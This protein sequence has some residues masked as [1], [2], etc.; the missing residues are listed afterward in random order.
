MS[1][2]VSTQVIKPQDFL[3]YCEYYIEKESKVFEMS[4]AV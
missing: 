4:N 2:L 1:I 3:I